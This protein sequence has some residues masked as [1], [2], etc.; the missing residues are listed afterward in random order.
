M[1][2]YATKQ[3]EM[4]E[5]V[6]KQAIYEAALRVIS[7]NKHESLRMQ[8]IAEAAG[9]AT[10]TLYNYFDCKESLLYYVDGRLREYFLT[11]MQSFAEMQGPPLQRLEDLTME[12]LR[13]CG[14]HH[15][16]FDLSDKFGIAN[17]IPKKEK[18]AKLDRAFDCIKSILDDGVKDRLFKSIDTATE[19]RCYLYALIGIIEVQRFIGERNLSKHGEELLK[20]FQQHLGIQVS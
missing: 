20:T 17:R 19:A 6:A 13:Y 8:E 9:I 4:K 14:E 10:G 12:I 11:K 18:L 7:Q 3:K 5:K 1:S 2:S 16:V 15:A